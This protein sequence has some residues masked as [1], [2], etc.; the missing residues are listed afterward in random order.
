M[1]QEMW[2]PLKLDAFATRADTRLPR[3][4]SLNLDLQAEATNV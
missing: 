2:S 3:L 1:V 4:W